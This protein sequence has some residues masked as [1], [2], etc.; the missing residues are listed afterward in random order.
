MAQQLNRMPEYNEHLTTKGETTRGW[1]S[2]FAGL[3]TGQPVGQPVSVALATSPMAYRATQGGHLI[4]QGGTVTMVSLSRDGV[5]N[6]NTGQ[7]Q[8]IFPLSQGDT[9]FITYTGT[10][11]LT[12]VPR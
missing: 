5:T 1:Y 4:I 11:V 12:F 2:F 6:F 10:P 8:G 3:F 7:T 9:L